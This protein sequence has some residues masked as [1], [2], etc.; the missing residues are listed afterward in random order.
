MDQ[1]RPL[2]AKNGGG[3]LVLTCM[4]PRCVP[5]QYFGPDAGAAAVRNAGGRATKDAINSIT[6]LHA[7]VD[8]R[9]VVVVHHTDCGMTHL[10]EDTLRQAVKAKAPDAAADIDAVEAYGTFDAADF[11]KTILEDVRTLRQAKVLA[12]IDVKG[13]ALDTF[14]GVITELSE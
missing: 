7:L 3:T 14:T 4:D 10:T 8:V 12:G 9:L 6:V 13:F 1:F 2:A 5:E 11:E